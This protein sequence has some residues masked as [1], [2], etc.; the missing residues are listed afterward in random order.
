MTKDGMIFIFDFLTNPQ[1]YKRG[2]KEDVNEQSSIEERNKHIN[3]LFNQLSNKIIQHK[4]G[5]KDPFLE[6]LEKERKNRFEMNKKDPYLDLINYY[7][8][9]LKKQ[10]NKQEENKMNKRKIILEEFNRFLDNYIGFD[11]QWDEEKALDEIAEI[12]FEIKNVHG[13]ETEFSLRLEQPKRDEAERD[14]E[15]FSDWDIVD[16][17]FEPYW[18][19]TKLQWRALHNFILEA[20]TRVVMW[21]PKK[22]TKMDN[23]MKKKL[24]N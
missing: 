24:L 9:K 8:D 11:Y 18:E 1:A 22:Q 3:D 5:E 6:N 12:E 21:D 4:R 19:G 20:L 14:E 23:I 16:I 13:V 2:Q 10:K 17:T 7:L 15:M